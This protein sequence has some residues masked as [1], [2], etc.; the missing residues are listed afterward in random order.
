MELYSLCCTLMRPVL[1]GGF[2]KNKNMFT[3]NFTGRNLKIKRFIKTKQ[4]N[5]FKQYKIPTLKQKQ[6]PG[7]SAIL[8]YVFE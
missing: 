4:G 7:L 5:F 6:V 8:N 1:M 2:R 3:E